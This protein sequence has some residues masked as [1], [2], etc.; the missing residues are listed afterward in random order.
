MQKLLTYM[1]VGVLLLAGCTDAK[2]QTEQPV[3]AQNP[4]ADGF[5]TEASDD[6][7]IALADSVMLAMGGRSGWDN[8]RYISWDFF[9]KRQLLW[10]KKADR[11]RIDLADADSTTMVLNLNNMSGA[12]RKNGQLVSDQDSLQK[13][14]EQAR[15]IW[16]NDS[17]W[18]VMPFKLKDSG[19]TLTY[20]G[21]DTLPG[22]SP[23]VKLQ[24]I[25]DQVGVTPQNKYHVW[26]DQS[27][28]LVKQ[29]A[30]FRQ[31]SD[32]EPA[33]VTPWTDYKQ[34][35]DILLAGNRGER[36][37]SGINVHD[38]VPEEQFEL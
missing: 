19:V 17:Y 3:V 10:D 11:V 36:Q 4:A 21:A 16:I 32:A 25:F 33:F 18:L 35:G 1:I 23:A 22:G 28:H 15:R 38:S 27:D 30:F 13:Y 31:A 34:Y 2:K 20:K 9:G 8:T 24:L 29:W 7:A 37:I 12:V 5:N 26:V 6:E 14:L